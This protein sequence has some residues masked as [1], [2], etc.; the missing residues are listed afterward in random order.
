MVTGQELSAQI[1]VETSAVPL[2]EDVTD[3]KDLVVKL[4]QEN[5]QNHRQAAKDLEELINFRGAKAQRSA[6]APITV[7]RAGG[8]NPSN[9]KL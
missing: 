3:L 7:V 6:T 8:E 4:T 1:G 2:P 9:P 5:E